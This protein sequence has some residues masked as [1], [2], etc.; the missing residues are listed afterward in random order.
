MTSRREL[1][2]AGHRA[3]Q[4]RRRPRVTIVGVL[5]ELLVTAGFLV[6]AFVGWQLWLNDI[7][8]G[9]QL[10]AIS[11]EITQEWDKNIG[12]AVRGDTE[13]PPVMTP[14]A[15]A[16]RFALLIVPRFGEDYYRPIAEGVGTWSVLNKNNLGHYPGTQMPGEVGN[17]AIAAH[18]KA[19]GGNLENIHKLQVGDTV[20]VETKDGWYGYVFRNLEYVTPRGVGV[21]DPVPQRDDVNPEERL[22]TMT[23][24]NPF[25]STAER[26]IAYGVFDQFYPRADGPPAEIAQTVQ[27]AS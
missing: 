6:L 3:K 14:V 7:I 21:I 23:T 2:E 16:E 12:E 5:G 27:A 24:C 9:H 18:R 22:I 8:V 26:I 15:D 20:Y 4:Q 13:E 10:E 17:F 19:Y 25:F 11:Q 1:R